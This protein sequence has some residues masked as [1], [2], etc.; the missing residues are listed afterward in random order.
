MTIRETDAKHR[1]ERERERRGEN[2]SFRY[3]DLLKG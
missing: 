1:E 2:L 3:L